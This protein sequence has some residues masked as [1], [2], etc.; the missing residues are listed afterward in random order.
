MGASR[1]TIAW[2]RSSHIA[3]GSST[4]KLTFSRT[5]KPCLPCAASIGGDVRDHFQTAIAGASPRNLDHVAKQLWTAHGAGL[6]SDD[7]AQTL[8]AAIEARRRPSGPRRPQDAPQALQR[9]RQSFFPLRRPQRSPDRARSIARRRRLAASGP[10]PPALA[11]H[12][13]TA[14]LS[15]LK[16]VADEVA[17]HGT[18]TRTI[19]EIAARAGVSR[20]SVLNA[21]RE[22]Q[23]L[24]LVTVEER[25]REGQRNLPNV[26][27]VV[28]AEWRTWLERGGRV[29][30]NAPHGYRS[31]P[32]GKSQPIDTGNRH[33]K[34]FR[35][36]RGQPSSLPGAV[37]RPPPGHRTT[38]RVFPDVSI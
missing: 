33:K 4:G 14:E 29:Q 26:V 3:P 28:S 6:L 24:G 31:I 23:T 20:T 9:H 32:E 27:R 11:C 2:S 1:N 38:Q 5:A 10:M 12:F 34:G 19:A 22:A 15:V 16:I 21:L 8:A 25:R 17:A 36:K 35:D 7:D 37:D 18:C 30:K 13:T